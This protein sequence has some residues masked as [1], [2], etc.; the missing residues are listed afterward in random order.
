MFNQEARWD[1]NMPGQHSRYLNEPIRVMAV[2]G[3]GRILPRYFFW[4]KKL[5]KIRKVT[6]GWQERQGNELLNIFSVETA[7]GLYE[8]SFSNQSFNW[9]LNKIL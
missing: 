5:Y 2:F 8:I 7:N 6:Y 3:G 1:R 9:N 4:H